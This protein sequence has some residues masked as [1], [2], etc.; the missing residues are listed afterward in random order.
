MDD[1]PSY[2]TLSWGVGETFHTDV[3]QHG[4]IHK[5]LQMSRVLDQPSKVMMVCLWHLCTTVC[6]CA[7][8]PNT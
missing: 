8:V 2:I 7:P 6:V 4:D 5:P 1:K 3:E